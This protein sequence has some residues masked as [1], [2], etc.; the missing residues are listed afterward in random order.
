MYP[1]ELRAEPVVVLL[2]IAGPRGVALVVLVVSGSGRR[3]GRK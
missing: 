3:V 2:V 1:D